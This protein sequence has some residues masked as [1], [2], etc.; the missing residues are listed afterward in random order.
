MPEIVR[1][2]VARAAQGDADD[3]AEVAL[4]EVPGVERLPFAVRENEGAVPEYIG[5]M[6]LELVRKASREFDHASPARLRGPEAAEVID[7]ALDPRQADS[8][9]DVTPAE[10]DRL[11]DPASDVGQEQD[12]RVRAPSSSVRGREERLEF[13]SRKHA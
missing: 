4:G 10:R 2:D 5:A 1:R 9:I 6:L 3:P 8:E 12:E 11:A 7:A 13:V